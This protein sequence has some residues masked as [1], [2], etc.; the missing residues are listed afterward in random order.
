MSCSFTALFTVFQ[1]YQADEM[2]I[3]KGCENITLD[4][5]IAEKISASSEIRT[6]TP[7]A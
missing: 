5:Y 3:I 4:V 1:S 7:R 2:M 6:L